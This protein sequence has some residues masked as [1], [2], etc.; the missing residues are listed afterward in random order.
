MRD[1]N[2]VY[3]GIDAHKSSFS[4]CCYAP[5]GD[6]SFGVRKTA[7]DYKEVLKYLQN[8]RDFYGEETTFVCGY[9]AG[10]LG[11]TL[12]RQLS[13]AGVN[14]IILA[15]TTMLSTASNRRIK[16]DKRD[17]ELIAKSLAYH[18]YSPVHVPSEL[19]EKIKGFIR[20]RDDHKLA[21]KRI[22]QQ[23][24]AFCLLHGLKYDGNYWTG[25]H[26]AWLHSLKLDEINQ[27]VLNEYESTYT[28]LIDKLKRFDKRIQE[29]AQ[30]PEYKEHVNNL[31]CLSGIEHHTALAI[32]TETGDFK[33][34][35]TANAY[36]SY[37]GLVPG[38]HSSSNNVNH[39]GITK[40]GNSHLRRLLIEAS[41]RYGKGKPGV[42]TITQKKKQ[43][44]CSQK[45]IDYADKAI[46][47]LKR[48]YYRLSLRGKSGNIV[49][50]AV[51]RELAGY[52]WGIMNDK[53]GLHPELEGIST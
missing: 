11:Y 14:C 23:I 40:A 38:E 44:G 39:L 17:A 50:T 47:H 48:K 1:Y 37:L 7:S 49:K 18:G 32:L 29:L 15:P 4:L 36:M 13:S 16:T 30:L 24:L 19:D 33:R 6:K 35:N 45:I 5:E 43:Q 9:E 51:A 52:I 42:K 46:E 21:L 34:F 22:K 10:C 28:M 12:Y 20:M 8:M 26:L 25:K 2:T 27:E 41:Q 53:I 31:R 3:V